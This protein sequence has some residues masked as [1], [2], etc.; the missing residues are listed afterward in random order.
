MEGQEL[1]N[2]TPIDSALRLLQHTAEIVDLFNSKLSNKKHQG[3]QAEK[4]EQFLF[5]YV[6][7]EREELR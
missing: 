3:H 1:D 5:F 4:V 2:G 6:G 7:L